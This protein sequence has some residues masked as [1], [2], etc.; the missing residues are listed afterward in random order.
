MNT[1]LKTS[2]MSKAALLTILKVVESPIKARRVVSLKMRV[3]VKL[4]LLKVKLQVLLF[5][6]KNYNQNQKVVD[7][8]LTVDNLPLEVVQHHKTEV[9]HVI[10][11][12]LAERILLNHHK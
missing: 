4:R 2:V 7:W 12:P 5:I 6:L 9:Q 3:K 1:K 11:C 10:Y 8:P